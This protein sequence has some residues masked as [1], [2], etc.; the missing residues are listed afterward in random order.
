MPAIPPE[1]E[2]VVF[3]ALAKDPKARFASVA[4]FSAALEQASQRALSS[5]AKHSDEQPAFGSLEVKGYETG[6]G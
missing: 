1:V 2:Q 6:A 5:T 4:A 3:Q